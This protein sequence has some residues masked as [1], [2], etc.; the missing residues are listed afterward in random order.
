MRNNI[1]KSRF[2]DFGVK[3]VF[4]ISYSNDEHQKEGTVLRLSPYLVADFKIF[5]RILFALF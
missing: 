1:V 5:G 3:A 4:R 2:A